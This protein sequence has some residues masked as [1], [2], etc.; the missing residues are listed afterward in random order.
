MTD[1]AILSGIRQRDESAI[2][3]VINK[4]SRLLWSIASAVLK[5]AGSDQDTEE[6]VA[7]AFIYLWQSPERFD[8]EKG[9]LKSWLSMVVRSRAIDR[10]RELTRR[11]TVALDDAMVVGR[12]GLQD[13][14]VDLERKRELSD[15]IRK[16][17]R[18][19]QDILLR[20][21]YYEQKPAQIALALNLSVKQVDNCLYRTKRKLKKALGGFY[22]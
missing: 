13:A 10:Y 4:Y 21:Y 1:K 14:L 17:E 12:M 2:S 9:N 19:E 6:C 18:Q 15:A 11:S 5:N 20:R 22:E 7:D 3:W 16:L 8:P